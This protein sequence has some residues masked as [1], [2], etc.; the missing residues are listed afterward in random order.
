MIMK[1]MYKLFSILICLFA[2]LLLNPFWPNWGQSY[3]ADYGGGHILTITSASMN[4]FLQNQHYSSFQHFSGVFGLVCLY[5]A[6]V[7]LVF[8]FIYNIL[9][10]K[11]FLPVELISSGLLVMSSI[12]IP[13]TNNYS[14][15]PFTLYCFLP[16]LSGIIL[17]FNYLVKMFDEKV[18]TAV[19]E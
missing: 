11:D 18:Q 14:L 9:R 16:A 8:T 13:F 6:F 12:F 19:M 4:S 10:N 7:I 17:A 3:V 2:L 15:M 1:K 5:S